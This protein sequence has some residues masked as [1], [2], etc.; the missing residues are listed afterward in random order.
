MAAPD[1]LVRVDDDDA[2]DAFVAGSPHGS[3]FATS[4][5][6]RALPVRAERWFLLVDGRAAAAAVQCLGDDGE[7]VREPQPSVAFQS[8]M[9]AGW[10][11]AKPG[12]RLVK[13]ELETLERLIALVAERYPRVSFACHP[14]L[15]DV[16]ALQWFNYH[17]P[18]N[19]RFRLDLRYTGVLDVR[20]ASR[21]TMLEQA[22]FARRYDWKQAVRAGAV[23]EVASSF[24]PLEAL[25]EQT[26]ARQG[27]AWDERDRRYLTAI[28]D[29]ALRDGY[30][31]VGLCRLP[32]GAVAS[33]ALFLYDRRTAYYLAAGTDPDARSLGVG[34]AVVVEFIARAMAMGIA[35]VDFCGVN[36]PQR[37]D[38][39]T[40]F[41]AEPVPYVLARWR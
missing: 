21:E 4:A 3:V 15:R 9:L 33:A 30:G 17:E 19:D 39:K 5:F 2:W 41:N 1:D 40:S 36:S 34:T 13:W 18:E 7:P 38:F 20:D 8:P 14:A 35:R 29:A 11:Y 37:G 10:G 31:E 26:F 24:A 12:H 23:F 28:A 27:G 22:R 32:G 6:L 16:R 25:I